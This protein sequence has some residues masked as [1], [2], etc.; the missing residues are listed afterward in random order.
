MAKNF[1]LTD[2]EKQALQSMTDISQIHEYGLKNLNI[3]RLTPNI[4]YTVGDSEINFLL[5]AGKMAGNIPLNRVQ[6][7]TDF[8]V[9]CRGFG[10]SGLDQLTTGDDRVNSFGE[11]FDSQGTP[12]L[13]SMTNSGLDSLVTNKAFSN[14]TI[15]LGANQL[16]K[17]TRTAERIDMLSRLLSQENLRSAGVYN[18]CNIGTYPSK[19]GGNLELMAL[20]DHNKR[21]PPTFCFGCD[22]KDTVETIFWHRNSNDQYIKRVA[23]SSTSTHPWYAEWSVDGLTWETGKVEST[24]GSNWVGELHQKKY[25]TEIQY[26]Y[27][28]R[29]TH[30]PD[31]DISF[32]TTKYSQRQTF[33]VYEDLLHDC[34]TTKYQSNTD[35]RGLPV[36]QMGITLN[37]SPNINSLFKTSNP[38]ITDITVVVK[39]MELNILTYSYG[40]LD[41]I[42]RPYNIPYYT[43]KQDTQVL[44]IVANPR[45]VIKPIQYNSM[46]TYVLLYNSEPIASGVK[47]N[48]NM[49]INVTRIKSVKL[50]INNDGGSALYTMTTDELRQRT[51]ANLNDSECNVHALWRSQ[52]NQ[53]EGLETKWK[54]LVSSNPGAG[55]AAQGLE[56]EW[57]NRVMRGPDSYGGKALLD[58]MYLLRI[59]RDIRI[60][61]QMMSSLNIPTIFNWDIEFSSIYATDVPVDPLTKFTTVAFNPAFYV[62]SPYEGLLKGQNITVS[63]EQMLEMVNS[64]NVEILSGDYPNNVTYDHISPLMV[65]SGWFGAMNKTLPRA[66]KVGVCKKNTHCQDITPVVNLLS[67]KKGGRFH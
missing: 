32:V 6:C 11:V 25:G 37:I 21:V 34:F 23:Y 2:I 27:E 9:V 49:N 22:I 5:S 50:T 26:V 63:E 57:V 42:P 64:T 7:V 40:A 12:Y 36:P 35:Y 55:I 15:S 20:Q 43:E 58:G 8:E 29:P 33:R 52:P 38:N 39:K 44:D 30:G 60:N 47:Q 54:F 13:F 28:E 53:C 45:P 56:A 51:L 16:Q 67:K 31:W 1:R 18:E 66:E 46:P 61:P 65:G 4:K 19:A 41:I 14:V 3:V 17:E 24:S 59:G 10:D 48:Q 62:V